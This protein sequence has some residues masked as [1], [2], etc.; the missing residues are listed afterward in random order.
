MI[1]RN[2]KRKPL[3]DDGLTAR[4]A[5]LEARLEDLEQ[6][7]RE[8]RQHHLRLAEITDVVQELLVPA[9]NRDDARV[10]HAADAFTETL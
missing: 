2:V 4:V 8:T 6:Q 10:A 7:L 5:A 1:G 9:V 3:P